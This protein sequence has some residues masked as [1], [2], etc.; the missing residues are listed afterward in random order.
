MYLLLYVDRFSVASLFLLTSASTA[1]SSHIVVLSSHLLNLPQHSQPYVFRDWKLWNHFLDLANHTPMKEWMLESSD[2][3][4]RNIC[5]TVK[6]S[7]SLPHLKHRSFCNNRHIN[8]SPGWSP[9][10]G[11]RYQTTI[12]HHG[13][14]PLLCANRGGYSFL[15]PS[16]KKQIS[17]HHVPETLT[18][19]CVMKCSW[20]DLSFTPN[21]SFCTSM[22]ESSDSQL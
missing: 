3:R 9:K 14:S 10:L 12:T 5:L 15:S 11:D 18:L 6:N 8:V 17:Q 13:T 2:L 21:I 19:L 16:T 1:T 22:E 20:I 4:P 7:N